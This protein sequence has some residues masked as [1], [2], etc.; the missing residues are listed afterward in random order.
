LPTS[1]ISAE[2]AVPVEEYCVLVKKRK[3]IEAAAEGKT[4]C[5]DRVPSVARLVKYTRF[6][7]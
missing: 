2:A 6:W 1:D 5:S 3:V 4:S 7:K